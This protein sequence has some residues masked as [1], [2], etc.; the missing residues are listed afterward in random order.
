MLSLQNVEPRLAAFLRCF[1]SLLHLSYYTDIRQHS[2]QEPDR[3]IVLAALD[4]LTRALRYPHLAALFVL[5]RTSGVLAFAYS[6]IEETGEM[7]WWR[8]SAEED[9]E[10][11]DHFETM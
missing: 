2:S 7:R 3:A 6:S 5:L 10:Y 9:F 8:S 11:C 4:P 1:P